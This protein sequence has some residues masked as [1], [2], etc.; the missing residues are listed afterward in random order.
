MP[1]AFLRKA[2]HLA[3]PEL[4]CL[5][6]LH[7][8]VNGAPAVYFDVAERIRREATVPA[9]EAPASADPPVEQHSFIEGT[10]PET[11]WDDPN[12]NGAWQARLAANRAEETAGA[13][14]PYAASW[15]SAAKAG[16]SAVGDMP[17][18]P[19]LLTPEPEPSVSLIEAAPDGTGGAIRT[20]NLEQY[21]G[22]WREFLDRLGASQV[23]SNGKLSRGP[24]GFVG[25]FES[26]E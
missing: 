26:A 12:G 24:Q 25:Q 19:G 14:Q 18:D 2:R 10:P 16:E 9:A 20:D 6:F 4:D 23:P 11:P 21:K 3:F 5:T 13:G 7:L 17:L 15:S 22:E 8:Q 1:D